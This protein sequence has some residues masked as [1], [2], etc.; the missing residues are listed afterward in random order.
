MKLRLI[1]IGFSV[2]LIGSCTPSVSTSPQIIVPQLETKME[3]VTR[4]D[5][6]WVPLTDTI[7]THEIKYITIHHG[8]EDFPEDKDVIKYLIG[9]QSWS[10]SDKNWIDNPYH[11]M[12][13]LQGNIYEARPIKYPGDT[14]TDYDVRGHALICV[15]GNYE[16]QILSKIQFEQ[17]ALLTATLADKYGVANDLI[18]SHKDYTETLCPGK[19]LYRYL[20]DG[21]LIKRVVE[22]RKP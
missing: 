18:K 2:L 21:S 17:L 10:R 22:L 16:N 8:G 1:F 19:D 3:M 12:I 14:N 11:Y 9:L 7:P 5:W 4:A 13:D 15:M 6:G 20:E